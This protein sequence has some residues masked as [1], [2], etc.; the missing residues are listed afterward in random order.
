[1]LP[2]LGGGV[3]SF[4]QRD[5]PSTRDGTASDLVGHT[6]ASALLYNRDPRD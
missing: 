2:D 4:V 3:R 6:S 5:E 1:M